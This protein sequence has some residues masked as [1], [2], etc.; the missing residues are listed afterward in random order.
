MGPSC[1]YCQHRCFLLRVLKTGKSI[2]LATC[3]AGMNNDL[4]RTGQT[5]ETSVNPV[6][7]P[8]GAARLFKAP[9]L[10]D[11]CEFCGFCGCHAEAHTYSANAE[12]VPCVGCKGGVCPRPDT[13]VTC[14]SPIKA[15]D[16]QWVVVGTR[17]SAD[18]L[19]YCP[20]NPDAD[21]AGEHRPVVTGANL[22][23]V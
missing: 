20:P 19:T 14:G 6:L 22:H 1:Q 15:V 2:L 17:T 11:P 23:R 7:D 3:P 9:E 21:P 5:H 16:G 10:Q 13:C 4:A 8:V 12:D 18:G